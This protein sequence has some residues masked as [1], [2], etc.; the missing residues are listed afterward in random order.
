MYISYYQF[1]QIYD[2]YQLCQLII[3]SVYSG[4]TRIQAISYCVLSKINISWQTQIIIQIQLLKQCWSYPDFFRFD[5][6]Q[7][8]LRNEQ[9]PRQ[10]STEAENS[11]P[12]TPER[13]TGKD[14]SQSADLLEVE[15]ALLREVADISEFL[16]Q[17]IRTDG[18]DPQLR[19]RTQGAM[20]ED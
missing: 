16:H 7:I 5:Y 10:L 6:S 1:L 3:V 4:N 13:E 17:H 19:I 11:L 12:P 15:L 18:E 9:K 20:Q 14:R 2:Y 8:P